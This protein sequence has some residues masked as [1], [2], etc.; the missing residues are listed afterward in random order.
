MRRRTQE[1]TAQINDEEPGA[2]IRKRLRTDPGF[3]PR[4][5]DLKATFGL[6][7]DQPDG[8]YEWLNF[9][10]DPEKPVF[11]MWTEEYIKEF[12]TY[13]L[14][15]LDDLGATVET[16]LTILEVGAGNGKL[17]YFLRERLNAKAAGRLKIAATDVQRRGRSSENVEELGYVEALEQYKPD[18]VI[19]SWMPK[20]Y[21]WTGAFRQMPSVK[22]YILIGVPS[23]TGDNEAWG[24][25]S[26]GGFIQNYSIEGFRRTE[27][28][29]LKKYQICGTDVP[30]IPYSYS[31]TASFRRE[32]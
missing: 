4:R 18:I 1:D 22:E 19:S 31:V 25:Y 15:R 24:I 23:L 5:E 26:D 8:L 11:E 21:D 13:L 9:V 27:L 2:R 14:T 12:S 16:P 20:F 3:L 17:T 32:V 7:D 6:P 29:D 28:H 30:H 10:H